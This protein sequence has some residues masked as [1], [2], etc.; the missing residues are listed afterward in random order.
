[1]RTLSE[2]NIHSTEQQILQFC[3][4]IPM[5]ALDVQMRQMYMDYSI[6]LLALKQQQKLLDEQNQYNQKQ[7]VWA[8]TV[9]ITAIVSVLVTLGLL[10][11][12]PQTSSRPF[13]FWMADPLAK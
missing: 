4:A 1:M 11:F 12:D 13:G 3:Q 9:A 7:L 8:R 2:I 5:M 10:K 6:N